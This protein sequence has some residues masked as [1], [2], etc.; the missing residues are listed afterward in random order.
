MRPKPCFTPEKKQALRDFAKEVRF[1]GKKEDTRKQYSGAMRHWIDFAEAAGL[2][3]YLDHLSYAERGEAAEMYASYETLDFQNKVTSIRGKLSAIRWMHIREHKPDPFKGLETLTTWLTE[4]EKAQPPKEP[5]AA[6]P[7]KL[8]ELIIQHTDTNTVVGAILASAATLGFWFLLRSI[9]YLASDCGFF[10]PARSV[11]WEDVVIRKLGEII[12]RH[13]MS[14][15]DEVTLTLYP[16]KGTLHTCTRSLKINSDS[17]SCA[18]KWLKNLY[19]VLLKD[20]KIP[21]SGDSLF[22]KPDGKDLTRSNLSDVFKV[23][24]VACGVTGSKVA[25]HFLRRGRASA[26]LAAQV[27]HAD[28]QKFGRWTSECYK[29]YITAHADLTVQGKVNPASIVPRFERN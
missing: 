13:R 3:P 27:P 14:E 26:Y 17:A 24:A 11:T 7:A 22:L 23:A 1:N 16:G 4:L 10:D 9:E 20:N 19:A 21:K 28:I 12:P 2:P 15:C 6:V 29:I 5:S 25:T 18:V 8:I